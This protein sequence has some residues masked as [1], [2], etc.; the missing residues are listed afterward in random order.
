MRNRK[1]LKYKEGDIEY[2]REGE[3]DMKE[4]LNEKRMELG[5]ILR[6]KTMKDY[7]ILILVL[8]L[9]I[10]P[11]LFYS[12]YLKPNNSNNIN[13]NQDIIIANENDEKEGENKKEQKNNSSKKEEQDQ[14]ED[15]FNP[16]DIQDKLVFI[17]NRNVDK[18]NSYFDNKSNRGG[19]KSTIEKGLREQKDLYV[20][21]ELHNE[22][23]LKEE[24]LLDIDISLKLLDMMKDTITK[25]KTEEIYS[26]LN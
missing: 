5:S 6:E 24:I 23:E 22:E 19:L 26:V 13:N 17:N 1:F 8:T 20:E 18:L 25:Q 14:V 9:M 11:V 3:V 15:T 12:F 4:T 7:L 21:A 10:G 16:K 2:L